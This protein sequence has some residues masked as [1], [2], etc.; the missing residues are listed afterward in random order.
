VRKGGRSRDLP[1]LL[2][3]ECPSRGWSKHLVLELRKPGKGVEQVIEI[4]LTAEEKAALD[5]SAAAV[6]ELGGIMR[7]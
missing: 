4:K 1:P 3:I 7:R 6:R 5:H 2:F